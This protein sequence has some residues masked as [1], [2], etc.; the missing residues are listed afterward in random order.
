MPVRCP[1][2]PCARGC[3]TH[4]TARSQRPRRQGTAAPALAHPDGP[5]HAPGVPAEPGQRR[6]RADQ[7]GA[8]CQSELPGSP[9]RCRPHR[10][11][12]LYGCRQTSGRS[13]WLAPKPA[14]LPLAKLTALPLRKPTAQPD[15]LASRADA[16]AAARHR[17]RRP[18]RRRGRRNHATRAYRSCHGMTP[19]RART[20]L[21][22]AGTAV[23]DARMAVADARKALAGAGMTLGPGPLRP[24]TGSSRNQHRRRLA[25]ARPARGTCGPDGRGAGARA[26][27]RPGAVRSDARTRSWNYRWTFDRSRWQDAR[28]PNRP[29]RCRRSRRR[30]TA[31]LADSA[32]I[33]L[34]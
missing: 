23:A 12:L 19:A 33:P 7:A 6:R 22:D 10:R 9:D 27:A 34:S 8:Y 2:T 14:A 30:A 18:A 11:S 20:A 25:Q 13:E 15:S 21:A 1:R 29:V 31:G 3:P 32:A 17:G 5:D 26:C 16:A 28:G 4:Q 24:G